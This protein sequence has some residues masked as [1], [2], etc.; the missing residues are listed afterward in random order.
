MILKSIFLCKS[1]FDDLRMNSIIRRKVCTLEKSLICLNNIYSY[2]LYEVA[3]LITTASC[4]VVSY[5]V[6][7][8]IWKYSP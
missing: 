8:G 7:A 1:I 5:A 2:Y 6:G 4:I 3:W